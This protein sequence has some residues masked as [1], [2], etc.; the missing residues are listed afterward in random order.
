MHL[1]ANVDGLGAEESTAGGSRV[2]GISTTGERE[3]IGNCTDQTRT[4]T[5]VCSAVVLNFYK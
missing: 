3:R 4:V 2:G 5:E 1:T